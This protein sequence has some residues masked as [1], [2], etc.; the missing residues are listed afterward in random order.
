MLLYF[1]ERSGRPRKSQYENKEIQLNF[2]NFLENS[3]FFLQM[4]EFSEIPKLALMLKIKGIDI[5]DQNREFNKIYYFNENLKETF[6][7]FFKLLIKKTTETIRFNEEFERI[8]MRLGEFYSRYQENFTEMVIKEMKICKQYEVLFKDA[9]FLMKFEEIIR[10]WNR[11]YM[12][13]QDSG[14]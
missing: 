1:L 14:K 7:D 10:K 3:G 4:Q 6:Q 5:F 9:E 2:K 11:I 13:L 12:N 8:L